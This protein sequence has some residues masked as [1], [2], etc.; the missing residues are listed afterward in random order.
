MA[1][2]IDPDTMDTRIAT[3]TDNGTQIGELVTSLNNLVDGLEGGEWEGNAAT[4]F[5][6]AYAEIRTSLDKVSPLVLDMA[7]ELTKQNEA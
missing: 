6:S 5:Y 3:A 4:S 1:I 2:K 7:A